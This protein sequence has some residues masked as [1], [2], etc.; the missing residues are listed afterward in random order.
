MND[1]EVA[2]TEC[3]YWEEAYLRTRLHPRLL[4]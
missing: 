4:V 1:I 3:P 2:H